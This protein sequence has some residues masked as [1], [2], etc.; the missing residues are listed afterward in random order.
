MTALELHGGQDWQGFL[1]VMGILGI[2]LIWARLEIHNVDFDDVA[3][4]VEEALGPDVEQTDH[5]D[6]ANPDC[7][8]VI[9]QCRKPAECTGC[10]TLGCD[11][12]HGLCWDCRLRCRECARERQ[13][14]Q[15]M[16]WAVGR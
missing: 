3:R 16:D 9:C 12:G 15:A 2:C 13:A 14:E 10:T 11:H 7:D 4:L 5:V 8:Q 6:C 1:V